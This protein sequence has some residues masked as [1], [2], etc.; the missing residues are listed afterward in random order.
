MLIKFKILRESNYHNDNDPK[1][2]NFQHHKD[3]KDKQNMDKQLSNWW[4]D[5]N[6]NSNPIPHNVYMQLMASIKHINNKDAHRYYAPVFRRKYPPGMHSIDIIL[7]E[8]TSNDIEHPDVYMAALNMYKLH[9]HDMLKTINENIH[10]LEQIRD[11]MT[12]YSG[13]YYQSDWEVPLHI[14]ESYKHGIMMT[15][16]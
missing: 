13:G 3:V 16:I 5:I 6:P 14:W 12:A 11:I 1:V 10:A 4:D 9:K 7:S 2:I 8:L 15:S